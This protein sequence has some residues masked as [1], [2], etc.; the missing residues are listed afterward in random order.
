MCVGWVHEHAYKWL[1]RSG[2]PGVGLT[3]GCK[4]CGVDAR[5]SLSHWAMSQAL[6]ISLLTYE[7]NGI[8]GV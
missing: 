5:C 2:V 8:L 1:L 4:L 6:E 7:K 3:D